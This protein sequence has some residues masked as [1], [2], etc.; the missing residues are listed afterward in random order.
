MKGYHHKI[1]LCQL[2]KLMRLDWPWSKFRLK[3]DLN[4]ILI[5]FVDPISAARYTNSDKKLNTEFEFD[6]KLSNL[7][8]N[9]WKRLDFSLNLTFLIEFDHFLLNSTIFDWIINIKTI[10][11]HLLIKK[12]LKMD[13][14]NRKQSEIDQIYIEIAIVNRI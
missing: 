12:W 3:S 14:F 13:K 10:F 9:G 1:K 7:I 8:E 11:F 2:C 4:H 6:Q 5:D